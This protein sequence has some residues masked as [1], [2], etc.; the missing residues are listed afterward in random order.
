ME[1]DGRGACRL[2]QG[3]FILFYNWG[4]EQ[5]H[6]LFG[7]ALKKGFLDSSVCPKVGK[8]G[9]AK[10]TSGAATGQR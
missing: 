5:N 8:N 9:G 6:D 4:A 1:R 10:P 2:R 3:G 7:F